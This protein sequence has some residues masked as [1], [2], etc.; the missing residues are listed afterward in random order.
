MATLWTSIL[1]A[2]CAGPSGP[3]PPDVP[4]AL[5]PP[6][7]QDMSL[8]ALATGVQIY[9]CMA[10]QEQ[11]SR[12]GWVFKAPDAELADRAG[13]KIGRHYAGPTWE[14]L[15]ASTVVGEV[16]ARDDGPDANSIPWLLLGAKSN[17]GDGVFSRVKSIQRIQTVGGKAPATP[18]GRENSQQMARVPYR[19]AYYFY[20]DRR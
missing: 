2:G 9:E 12:Y 20:V 1:T 13:R 5:R 17:S 4:E 14:S 6:S 10:N 3:K 15:D 18:C 19:A 11:P 16:K 8:E 7:N